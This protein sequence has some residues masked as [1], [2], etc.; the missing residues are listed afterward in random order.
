MSRASIALA[1]AIAA[2]ALVLL[3][4][5]LRPDDEARDLASRSVPFAAEGTPRQGIRKPRPLRRR[6]PAA[7]EPAP[8]PAQEQPDGVAPA[9][10]TPG[11]DHLAERRRRAV[12]RRALR[13]ARAAR[14]AG[15]ADAARERDDVGGEA[16][17]EALLEGGIGGPPADEIP[18][19]PPDSPFAEMSKDDILEY[20][21]ALRRLRD[22]GALRRVAPE[23]YWRIMEIMPESRGLQD[24]DRIM[25][26]LFGIGIGE[27]LARNR[28]PQ[29]FSLE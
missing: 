29:N 18:E 24:A 26:E 15:A 28:G 1:V 17:D 21:V 13:A 7:G 12:A 19:F 16:D 14:A 22:S 23:D 2:V 27:W 25:R 6:I 10:T 5:S 11:A 9:E 8:P 4:T 3:L 20:I